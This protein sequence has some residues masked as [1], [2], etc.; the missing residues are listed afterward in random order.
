[1][2]A[3]IEGQY[4]PCSFECIQD[5]PA[6]IATIDPIAHAVTEPRRISDPYEFAES[7]SLATNGEE[8]V[9]TMTRYDGRTLVTALDASL[10]PVAARNFDGIADVAWDGSS[11]VLALR[12]RNRLAVHRLDSTLRD[13]ARTRFAGI[14]PADVVGSAPSV[15]AAI[16]GNAAIGIQE[17]DAGNG[18]RAVAYVEQ[19]LEYQ[20]QRRRIVRR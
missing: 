9:A 13:A 14:A 7:L 5:R 4:Y 2:I 8:I 15:A 3:W 16:P 19:E 18:A 20:S 12:E 10:E 11:F 1:V 17:V 6:F